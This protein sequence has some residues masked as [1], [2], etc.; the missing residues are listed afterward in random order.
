MDAGRGGF[1]VVR[2]FT[3][4]GSLFGTSDVRLR[5]TVDEGAMALELIRLQGDGMTAPAEPT[6]VYDPD[7]HELTA[8]P[9][10]SGTGLGAR[11]VAAALVDA[12]AEAPGGAIEITA[13]TTEVSPQ[14]TDEQAGELAAEANAMTADGL[15]LRV[16]DTTARVDAAQLREWIGLAPPEVGFG[17]AIDGTK[18][19][20]A[21][22]G[23]F[24]GLPARRNATVT[25]GAGGR[26][27]VVP[28]VQG[29]LCCAGGSAERI[30]EALEAG[31]PEVTLDAEVAEPEI[32]TEEAQAWGIAQPVGGN[33]AWRDGAEAPGPA[34]GFTTYYVPGEPRVTNIHRIADLVRGAVIPPGGSFSINDHVGER[35][36]DKGFVE[37]GAIRYGEHVPEVGGGVSQFAT[38]TF[39]AAYFAGLDITT[40]QAHT[41]Y[42]SRYPRGREATMGYPY[43]DLVIE[44]DTPYGVLI[45]TSYTD[46]SLTVTMYS[47]PYARAEQTGITESPSQQCTNVQTTRTR[48][49][50]DGTTDTDTFQ[51]TYRPG[52]GIGCDGKPITPPPEG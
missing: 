51:A 42:F 24:A 25:L 2:P 46:T 11:R 47:T 33:R 9:G 50:P 35:T 15:T 43:P 44:N 13:E 19:A 29:T 23:L 6:I 40:Y 38:T 22:P 37:A 28:A 18:V 8:T 14:H 3:W 36:L 27:E 34:P 1:V 49:Y 20:D 12:V 5:T 4:L 30:W 17:L 52:P 32:T 48:T 45:W 7:T 31:E 21:L 39:N 16:G 26:P 41:E 10:R